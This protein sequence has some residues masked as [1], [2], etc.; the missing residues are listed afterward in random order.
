[1][2]EKINDL[3]TIRDGY[4]K[5]SRGYDALDWAIKNLAIAYDHLQLTGKQ[6]RADDERFIR[7]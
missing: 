5:D 6:M 4:P 2:L 3:I 7:D 1:M